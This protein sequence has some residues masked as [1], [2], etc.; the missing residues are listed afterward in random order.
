MPAGALTTDAWAEARR[1][2]DG[3]PDERGLNIAHEAVDRHLLHGDGGR[4]ALRTI[5]L[6]EAV[7]EVTYADLAGLTSAFANVLDEIGVAAG[8]AVFSLLGRGLDIYVAA[9]GTLKHGSV[10][11][12]LFTAFGPEPIRQRLQLGHGRVL[13]TTAELYRR[14]VADLREGLPDLEHVLLVDV[15]PGDVEG[16]LSLHDLLDRAGRTYE[17]PPTAPETPALLH[18][19]SG[20]TGRPKGALHV[21]EAVVAHHATA[22]HALGLRRDDVFWCTA[23]PGWVTGTSYGIIAPLTHGATVVTDCGEFSARRWYRILQDQKVTVWYT[24]PTA[25][26][27]LMRAGGRDRE[28]VRPHGAAAH[29]QRRG[30]AQ[31]RGRRVGAGDLPAARPGQLVADRDGRHHDQQPAGPAGAPRVDGPARPRCRGDGPRP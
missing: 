28:G 24:A 29:L 3:L 22:A 18:F 14:R 17:I 19:T 6:D 10:F 26:R 2:L 7:A 5:G 27:M 15:G 8:D 16:T 31:P 25:L 23:D 9:L 12:P 21:H 13:V 30:A 20:T 11:C 4:V 1:L